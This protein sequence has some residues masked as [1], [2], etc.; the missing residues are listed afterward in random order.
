MPLWLDL[1]RTPMAAPE[2]AELRRLRLC[3]Q[4]LC[5][6]LAG[7]L[8]LFEDLQTL[9]PGLATPLAACLLIATLLQTG[10]YWTRKN[11]ADAALMSPN[12]GE[13]K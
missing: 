12:E 6:A 5:L 2:T 8:F 4:V 3:W 1:L 9:A 10:L 7:T 11:R 13:A